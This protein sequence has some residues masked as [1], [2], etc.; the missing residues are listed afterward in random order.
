MIYYSIPGNDKLKISK[1]GS[2]LP[3]LPTDKDK[4]NELFTIK[5]D[6]ITLDEICPLLSVVLL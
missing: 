2:V 6:K 5:D 4:C 1:T 3:V